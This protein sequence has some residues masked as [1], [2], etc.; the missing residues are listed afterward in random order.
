MSL[1][2]GIKMEGYR[3]VTNTS[4]PISISEFSRGIE[5][6][7]SHNGRQPLKKAYPQIQFK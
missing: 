6:S 4:P 3:E 5:T 1:N 2:N 7:T